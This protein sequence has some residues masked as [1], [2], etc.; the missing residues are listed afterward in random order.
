MLRNLAQYYAKDP[1]NLFMVRIAQGLTHL[2]KGTFTLNA[3]HSDRQIISPIAIAG[4]L[5]TIVSF[6]DIKSSEYF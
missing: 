1:N 2:G 6:L 5:T 3:F 4:L